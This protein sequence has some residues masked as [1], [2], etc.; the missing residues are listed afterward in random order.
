[1]CHGRE[2]QS[3][4]VRRQSPS[5]H[6][7]CVACQRTL[8]MDH[9]LGPGRRAAGIEQ[10][11]GTVGICHRQIATCHGSAAVRAQVEF[12]RNGSLDTQFRLRQVRA[13]STM[14]QNVSDFFRCQPVVDRDRHQ[15]RREAR[16]VAGGQFNAVPPMQ[17]NAVSW[18]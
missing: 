4:V 17:R 5:V 1:M 7:K 12:P 15:P 8:R 10:Q 3:V 11:G 14:F 13:R 9:A 2:Q 18:L 16:I 6:V